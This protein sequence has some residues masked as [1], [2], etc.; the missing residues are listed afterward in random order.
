MFPLSVN[1]EHSRQYLQDV[2]GLFKAEVYIATL[3]NGHKV[4][5]KDYSRFRYRPLARLLARYL[6]KREYKALALLNAWRYSPKVHASK[7]PLILVQEYIEGRT[8]NKAQQG[9]TATLTQLERA[10]KQLH[11]YGIAHNDI[12]ANNIIVR[13]DGQPVLIDFTSASLL[14]A[15]GLGW[16]QNK[17]YAYDQRH[18][19]KIKRQLGCALTAKDQQQLQRAKS[20]EFILKVWKGSILPSLKLLYKR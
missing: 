16:L 9:V 18:L 11:G 13:S 3:A 20:L 10:L 6:V 12:H 14:S 15:F 8:I 17:L 1:A 4:V 2:K 7:N 19:V 5:C